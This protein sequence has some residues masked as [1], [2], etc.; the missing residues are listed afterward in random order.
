MPEIYSYSATVTVGSSR[1]YVRSSPNTSA[2]LAGS[3]ILDP[4]V[5]VQVKGWCYGECVS[6]ECRW[7]VS[8]YGNYFWSG[9]TIE[10]PPGTPTPPVT[11]PAPAPA[12][13]P[14]PTAPTPAPSTP[15]EYRVSQPIVAVCPSTIFEFKFEDTIEV[16]AFNVDDIARVYVDDNKVLEVGFQGDQKVKIHPG[17]S[18]G[19]HTIKFTLENTKGGW[20]YGFD[21]LKNGASVLGTTYVEGKAGVTGARNNDLGIGLVVDIRIPIKI[22][23]PAQVS[24]EALEWLSQT[25]NQTASESALSTA[26]Y[27]TAEQAEE[28]KRALGP[29]AIPSDM[30]ERAILGISGIMTNTE[31]LFGRYPWTFLMAAGTAFTT[32]QGIAI[33]TETGAQFISKYPALPP[34]TGFGTEVAA[35]LMSFVTLLGEIA[36]YIYLAFLAAWYGLVGPI[37]GAIQAFFYFKNL[38]FYINPKKYIE[39]IVE[40]SH[41]V[42]RAKLDV[43][44]EKIDVTVWKIDLLHS[45]VDEIVK[46]I[47]NINEISQA[48]PKIPAEVERN[49]KELVGKVDSLKEQLITI[50][51]SIVALN[52]SIL[53]ISSLIPE[54]QSDIKRTIEIQKQSQTSDLTTTM[55]DIKTQLLLNLPER[56]LGRVAQGLTD[57]DTV[58]RGFSVFAQVAEV[59]MVMS[60]ATE[61]YNLWKG[62]PS[63][64]AGPIE[65]TMDKIYDLGQEVSSLIERPE[66]ISKDTFK[67]KLRKPLS[68]ALVG[69]IFQIILGKF[70]GWL[71]A[72]TLDELSAL[73]APFASF[74]IISNR[75][76]VAFA[77]PAFTRPF[78]WAGNM[79]FPTELPTAREVLWWNA[80][81]ILEPS[82]WD[83][84]KKIYG[85]KALP[86]PKL[87]PESIDMVLR[88][89]GLGDNFIEALKIRAF[90]PIDPFSFAFLSQTGYFVPDEVDFLVRDMGYRPEVRDY[91]TKAPM[92]WGLSPFKTSIRTRI[93]NGVSDGFIEE[94]KAVRILEKLWKILDMRTIMTLEAQTRYW[95]ETTKDRVDILSD[96]AVKEIISEEEL[97]TE[98]S[99]GPV[100]HISGLIRGEER[101]EEDLEMRV[102][103]P[104][105]LESYIERVRTKK[106]RRPLEERLPEQKRFILSALTSLYSIGKYDATKFVETLKKADEITD[107]IELAKLRADLEREL[108]DYRDELKRQR[109]ELKNYLSLI[110][111]I[112]VSE[113]R[114][115]AITLDVLERRLDEAEK[116]KDRK[117]AY[118]KKAE[119]ERELEEYQAKKASEKEEVKSY[120]SVVAST[121]VECYEEGA[122]TKD[123]LDSELILAE[124]I[125]SRRVAYALKAQWARFLREFR[126]KKAADEEKVKEYLST[127]AGSIIT[128]FEQG[129]IDYDTMVSE[130]EFAESV[131]DKKVAY[132]LKGL[133]ERFNRE[134]DMKITNL[135]AS[136]DSGLITEGSFYDEMFNLGI[137]EWRINAEIEAYEIKTYGKAISVEAKWISEYRAVM[138]I[139]DKIKKSGFMTIE[140]IKYNID[141][142]QKMVS[143]LDI[144]RKRRK[145][146]TFYDTQRIRV[147][148]L[149]EQFFIDLITEPYLY[150]ELKKIIV[151][152]DTLEKVF[153][154][155][156]AEKSKREKEKSAPAGK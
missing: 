48:L 1:L 61:A 30:F 100:I 97:R 12:P 102:V 20:T 44:A 52:T 120:L 95:Y 26:P 153:L 122:I 88:M 29:L 128:A 71:N 150:E 154:E 108:D 49:T 84:A 117:K 131:T 32:E 40:A 3:Q 64:F 74:R 11:A 22:F 55:A 145:L 112:L 121:L 51:S 149:A 6:G 42:T 94:E 133:W 106:F 67:E 144:L 63:R 104:D 111:G 43:V 110:A 87:G 24:Q 96:K 101:L 90:R 54:V 116:I 2:S 35:F 85:D 72:P 78:R 151:V 15:T 113:Y 69:Y 137:Q 19:I 114:E 127:V 83:L 146:E 56:V 143:A 37:T 134:T 136:L 124:Q 105:K 156:K 18:P 119:Y 76:I 86:Q 147:E 34:P 132:A 139:L 38:S 10:K 31:K 53:A 138:T 107:F 45:K 68:L 73:I 89:R 39:D 92:M 103:N 59:L 98:L 148:A 142:I 8:M 62:E 152:P 13:A 125:T 82:Q 50:P 5:K 4:G 129:K 99:R 140:Q 47:P 77:T 7:W 115:G 33:F 70:A 9:G 118:E 58:K 155:I 81:G 41:N 80:R 93:M 75:M 36:F 141:T 130:L 126:D 28:L 21:I 14:P 46:I 27:L 16:R 79:A 17:L 66:A 109:D 60:I 135:R 65:M 91:L 57:L 25:L 123:R 23:Y